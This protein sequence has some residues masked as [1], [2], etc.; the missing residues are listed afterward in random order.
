MASEL[1]RSLSTIRPRWRLFAGVVDGVM[2]L[3][4]R[5]RYKIGCNGEVIS[6]ERQVRKYWAKGL[7]LTGKSYRRLRL[8]NRRY[9]R[10]EE[11]DSCE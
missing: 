7:E 4:D 6:L 3:A 10:M 9:A 5:D 11:A 1:A 2:Y 8:R